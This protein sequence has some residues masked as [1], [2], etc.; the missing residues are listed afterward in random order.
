M[1]QLMGDV[2]LVLHDMSASHF[3]SHG[4]ELEDAM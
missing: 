4:L 3:V 2:S 1:W